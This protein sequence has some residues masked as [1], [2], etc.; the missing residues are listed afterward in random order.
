MARLG[1][2]IQS[3]YYFL[4]KLKQIGEFEKINTS[5]KSFFVQEQKRCLIKPV[6]Q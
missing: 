6:I 5:N 3:V 2:Y 4:S 1:M